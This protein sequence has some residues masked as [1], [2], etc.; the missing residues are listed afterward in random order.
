M[1]SVTIDYNMSAIQGENKLVVE[2]RH[3]IQAVVA[4]LAI[5][6]IKVAMIGDEDW[7][8]RLVA[9]DAD[10]FYS[11]V[12]IPRM[13]AGAGQGL[14]IEVQIMMLQA[15]FCQQIV[16]KRSQ[17]ETSE[18]GL[19]PLVVGMATVTAIGIRQTAVHTRTAGPLPGD[20]GMTFLAAIGRGTT[21]RCMTQS[22]ILL[23][24]GMGD[25]ASYRFISGTGRREWAW[26]KWAAALEP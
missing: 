13:A 19:S 26:A 9:I 3:R 7:L 5:S 14:L 11:H 8:G 24:C 16:F 18:V 4:G 22:A 2:F 25:K 17:I 23:K 6:A 1:T 10:D 20:I 21:P 12:A 15:E